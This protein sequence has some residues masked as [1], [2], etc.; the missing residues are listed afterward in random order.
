MSKEKQLL[1]ITHQPLAA[2]GKVHFKVKKNVIKRLTFTSI[3]KLKTKKHRQNELI[4][5]SWWR[6]R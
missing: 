2:A 5:M 3:I 4:D 6:W 1:C